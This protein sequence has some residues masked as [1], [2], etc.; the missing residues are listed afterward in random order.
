MYLTAIMDWHSRKV[1]SWKLSNSLETS[2]CVEALKKL[3]K[4]TACL[5]FL[6]GSRGSIYVTGIYQCAPKIQ[7]KISMDGKGAVDN[8]MIE[9]LWRTVNTNACIYKSLIVSST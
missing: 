4:L 1:L 7:Y 5:L 2:F 3:L 8:V 6:M 9:R